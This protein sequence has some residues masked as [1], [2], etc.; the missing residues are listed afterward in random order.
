VGSL[1]GNGLSYL[2]S[3]FL[4]RWLSPSDFG[5]Y[6]LGLTIFNVVILIA[7]LGFETGA[8]RFIS[9]ALGRNDRAAAQRSVVQVMTLVLVSGFAAGA[10]LVLLS[11]WLAKDIYG[12][13]LLSRV[14]PWFAAAVPLAV[15]S[16]VLLD[17][18][19]S[20]QLVRYTVLVK[21]VWEPVGKFLIA[22]ALFWAGYA[23][24]GV[25]AALLVS[26][27]G[28]VAIAVAAARRAAVFD[29][30]GVP[31]LNKEGLRALFM[32]CLPLT[33]SN[34][35]GVVAPRSDML[36]LGR[37]VTP[38]ELGL[39][40]VAVQ[41]AA[42]LVLVLA[43]FT[44]MCTPVIGEIAARHDLK[45]LQSLYA[46]VARWTTTCTVPLFCLYAVFG[47]DILAL[48]GTRFAAGAT[49]MAILAFGQ[50]IYGA[51]GLSSTVLLMFG[52]SR[53]MLGNTILLSLFLIGTNWLLVPR[54][55]IVGAACAVALTSAATGVINMWQVRTL[56]GVSPLS[57]ALTKP[58]IAGGVVALIA[59]SVKNMLAPALMPLLIALAAAAYVLLLFLLRFEAVDRQAFGAIIGR[60]RP[61]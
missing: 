39:Y 8:L 23:L 5:V 27:A 22:G 50:V 30:A 2:Y 44:T 4:A 33:V 59:W 60:I 17:V 10:L 47:T 57:W 26:T 40:S 41:T 56:Y 42:I 14:L 45:R 18:I 11:P 7:P 24:S 25:L 20:F 49:P 46:A 43:A 34:V 19:R 38:A 29:S 51:V 9:H 32:Y 31:A 48:F 12:S 3:M 58:V 35:F 1:F 36:I 52:H 13:P 55:G 61:A 37:W 6:A 21:Y 15:I 28:S 16:T 54:L 53:R